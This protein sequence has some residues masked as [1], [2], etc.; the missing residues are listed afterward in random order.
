M[1]NFRCKIDVA[2]LQPV[3]TSEIVHG[4]EDNFTDESS[5]DDEY[6]THITRAEDITGKTCCICLRRMPDGACHNEGN[7]CYLILTEYHDDKSNCRF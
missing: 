5:A 6:M 1:F 3:T 2:G 7:N 4:I